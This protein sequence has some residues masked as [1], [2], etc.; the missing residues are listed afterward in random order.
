MN[1]DSLS[2]D[3]RSPLFWPA[4]FGYERVVAILLEARADPG[5]VDRNGDTAVIVARKNG[6]EDNAKALENLH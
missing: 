3:M 4:R 6:H 1:V 5:I 2:T